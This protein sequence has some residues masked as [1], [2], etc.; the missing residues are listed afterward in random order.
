MKNAL[1]FLFAFLTSAALLGQDRKHNF[2]VRAEFGH[3]TTGTGDLPGQVYALEG[4][5]YFTK[6]FKVGLGVNHG[7]MG[8]T[9][10]GWIHSKARATGVD[11]TLYADLLRI[12]FFNLEIGAGGVYRNWHWAY[13]TGPDQYFYRDKLRL[14]PSSRG[15][16]N[17]GGV[18]Y[19][20]SLGMNFRL[21][22]RVGASVRTT[23]QNDT[24]ANNFITL[25]PGIIVTL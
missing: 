11:L 19:T 14:E 18:G 10:I 21:S 1:L 25:R 9:S 22:P 5:K 13:E 17:E 8:R 3:A 16:F 23:Y 4:G 12:G 7:R 15:S 24:N 2:F 20:A 6:H